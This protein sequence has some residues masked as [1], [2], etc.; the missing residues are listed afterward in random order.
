[1]NGYITGNLFESFPGCYKQ[2]QNVKMKKK[3][4]WQTGF[5]FSFLEISL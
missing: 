1:M 5:L 3:C 2:V 4:F